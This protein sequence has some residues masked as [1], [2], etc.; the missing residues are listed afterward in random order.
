MNNKTEVFDPQREIAELKRRVEYLERRDPDYGK[1]IAYSTG[2]SNVPF[3]AYKMDLNGY[4]TPKELI[5]QIKEMAIS[6]Q[7]KPP[8]AKIIREGY[9]PDT[10]NKENK[11]D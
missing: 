11:L 5:E 8:A 10:Y 6:T 4:Q 2:L 9:H 7:P 1:T 3:D